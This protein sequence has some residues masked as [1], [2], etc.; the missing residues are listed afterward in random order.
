MKSD[1]AHN[2]KENGAFVFTLDV[3]DDVK[4]NPPLTY[5]DLAEI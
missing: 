4:C 1:A 2:A 3:G 5:I